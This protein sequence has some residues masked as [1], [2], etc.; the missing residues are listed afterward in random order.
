MSEGTAPKPVPI[1]EQAVAWVE[2]ELLDWVAEQIRRRDEKSA[3]DLRAQGSGG[4]AE[5]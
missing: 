3:S 1:G 2:S 4:P 5:D